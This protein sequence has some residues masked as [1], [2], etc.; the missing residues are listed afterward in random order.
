MDKL[1]ILRLVAKCYQT[2]FLYIRILCSIL[3]LCMW[4]SIGAKSSAGLDN[5]SK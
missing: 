4:S 1:H 5:T 3:D 2:L